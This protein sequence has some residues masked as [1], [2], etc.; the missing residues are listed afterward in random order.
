MEKL[1]DLAEMD[2]LVFFIEK[3][4]STFDSLFIYICTQ[5]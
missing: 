1:T 5:K 2:K 4:L 3:T